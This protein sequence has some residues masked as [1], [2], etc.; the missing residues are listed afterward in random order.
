MNW[1]EWIFG[2]LDSQILLSNEGTEIPKLNRFGRTREVFLVPPLFQIP[3]FPQ[4][5]LSYVE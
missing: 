5:F 2:V 1:R 3:Y 4:K